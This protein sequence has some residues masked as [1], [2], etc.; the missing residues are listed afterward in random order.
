[1]IPGVYGAA[2]DITQ[3]PGVVVI[4]TEMIHEAR[5]ILLDARP[6]LPPPS[7]S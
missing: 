5:V 3:A 4:R 2:Y 7:A 1:M 6:A